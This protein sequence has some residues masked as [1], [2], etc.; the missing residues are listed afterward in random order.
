MLKKKVFVSF[1]FDRDRDYYYLLKAWNSNPSIEFSIIDR[2]PS[3]IQSD[4]VGVVKRVLSRKIN[5]ADLTL[6]VI[7]RDINASHPD[8]WSIGCVNWQNYEIEKSI[9]AGKRVVGIRLDRRF[10]LPETM[11]RAGCRVADGFELDRIL[12]LLRRS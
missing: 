12:A 9:G 11:R 1:D 3:E 5:E 10:G 8:R 7:G 4:S 2:T 6:V